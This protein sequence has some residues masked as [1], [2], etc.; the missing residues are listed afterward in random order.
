MRH[1]LLSHFLGYGVAI[2]FIFTFWAV[3]A[4]FVQQPFLP[5]PEHVVQEFIRLMI[6]QNLVIHFFSSTFRILLSLAAAIFTAVPIGLYVG[7]TPILDKFVAPLIY[8]LYPLPKIVFLPVIIIFFGLGD[9][10]KIFLIALIVFFQILVTA[11]DAARDIPRQWLLSMKSLKASR[12]QTFYHLVWPSSLPRI[13]TSLR[14]SLG[15]AI[16]VL[17]MAETFAS[18]NGLGYYIMDC[19]VRRSF[20]S[21]YSGILAMGFLGSLCYCAVD[22]L[23]RKFCNWN[24]M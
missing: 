21:M 5:S 22:I 11:R 20:T 15:T 8:L 19:M 13:F 9:F 18:S 6:T 2:I 12:W 23:E 1:K 14:V 17:F 7:W 16:A 4:L 3:L 24:R 10:P